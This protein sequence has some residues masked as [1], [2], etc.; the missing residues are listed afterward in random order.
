M[1]GSPSRALA[2]LSERHGILPGYVDATGVWRPRSPRTLLAL[3]RL[4]DCPIDRASEAAERLA[5]EERAREEEFPP[6]TVAVSGHLPRVRFRPGD[7]EHR[8]RRTI[9]VR[10]EGRVPMRTFEVN[11]RRLRGAARSYSEVVIPVRLP[12]GY[13]ELYLNG[14]KGPRTWLLVAPQRL[15]PT[16]PRRSWGV[17]VPLYSLWDRRGLGCGDFT[18]LSRAMHWARAQGARWFGVL[19]LTASYLDHPYEP[20]P[21]RPVSRSHWN[22]IY[23]DPSGGLGVRRNRSSEPAGPLVDF[24]AIQTIRGTRLAARA[25]RARSEGVSRRGSFARWQRS[26]PDVG[27]YARF[28]ARKETASGS[29]N[30]DGGEEDRARYHAFVQWLSSERLRSIA[31]EGRRAGISLYLDL[32]V[33]VH[34]EGFDASEDHLFVTGAE[35]GS[36]PDPGY[37]A[38]QRWGIPPPHPER[39]RED[40]YADF[41][42][43]IRRHLEVAG[44]LRIDHVMGL[45][46]LFW[47]PEEMRARDGAYVRYHPEEQ[48]AM[49]LIEASRAGAT[50]VGEDLGTVPPEVRHSMTERG[51]LRS[52]VAQ[53]EWDGPS[54]RRPAPIP[55]D[56]VASLNTHDMLPFA[57]YWQRQRHRTDSGPASS[58]GPTTQHREEALRNALGRLG[59]SSAAIV[60]VSLDDLCGE[61]V[62]QN[63]PGAVRRRANFR[64]RTRLSFEQFRDDPT[65]REMLRGLDRA[66]RDPTRGPG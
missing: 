59:R 35:I 29:R 12:I 52:F 66:R 53:L 64:R 10:R 21:Y 25:R 30:P 60:L 15:P 11:P 41:A 55:T 62:P 26:H 19:P 1:T 43:A 6:V 4:L 14:E 20:S 7:G 61:T 36:P 23:L 57:T 38:G 13:H 42:R 32:P 8:R 58:W 63:V 34:P 16:V 5:E 3:L 54:R 51:I 17:F 27:E 37:P 2:R 49:L 18:V 65:V 48:Y 22:E 9:R 40:G 46:R 47:V 50:L 33:G 24:R 44:A 39:I 28:R 56:A 31:R 45:H